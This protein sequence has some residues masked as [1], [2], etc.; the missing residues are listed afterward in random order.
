MSFDTG[1]LNPV[2]ESATGGVLSVQKSI[3][4]FCNLFLDVYL[5]L[6]EFLVGETPCEADQAKACR[7]QCSGCLSEQ[8][9]SDPSGV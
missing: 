1:V 9:N 5:Q 2:W 6:A 4:Y 8:K 7:D 3:A